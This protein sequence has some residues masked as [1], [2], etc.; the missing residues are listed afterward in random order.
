MI[1]IKKPAFSGIFPSLVTWKQPSIKESKILQ[2]YLGFNIDCYIQ[3]KEDKDSSYLLGYYKVIND[4]PFFIKL[5]DDDENKTQKN[6]SI[7]SSWL[8]KAGIEVSLVRA[9]YPKKIKQNNYWIYAYDFIE[10]SFFD[11]SKESLYLVGSELA[12]MHK[13]MK[14][15]P[16]VDKIFKIGNRKNKM[17]FKQLKNIKKGKQPINISAN[18]IKIIRNTNDEDFLSTLEGGQMIHGDLNGGNIIFKNRNK[19]PIFIDF[20]DSISTWLPP[21]YDVAFVIQRLV[22]RDRVLNRV[23]LVKSFFDG[24]LSQNKLNGLSKNGALYT[25][26]KMISIR[27][28]LLISTAT[29]NG[30][31]FYGLEEQKFLD[32]YAKI[33]KNKKMIMQFEHQ[34]KFS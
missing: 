22:L 13:I 10:H 28:L 14:H 24:Y 12:K 9:G 15:Y 18:A 31:S 33:K 25:M 5:V 6:A 16:S 1:K 2:E 29:P 17:L 30:E 4:Q 34:V 27:S 3:K 21:L 26:L 23:E 8:S 32:L 11:G 7:I 19:Q 20:E